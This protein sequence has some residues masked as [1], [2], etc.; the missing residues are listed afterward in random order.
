M[1]NLSI[2][3]ES[4]Q[5]K[6][7]QEVSPSDVEMCIDACKE[8]FNQILSGILEGENQE[9]HK[10][11]KSLFKE[12]M[13]LGLLLLNL[14]FANHN[15]G[16]YGEILKTSKGIARRGR[17]SEKSYFSVFGK[18]KVNRYLYNIGDESFAPLDTALNLPKRL[19]C[20][21]YFGHKKDNSYEQTCLTLSIKPLAFKLS[22]GQIT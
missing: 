14:F 1:S 4:T 8:Q 6:L 22:R 19:Y 18:L 15:Q 16:D 2:V 17:M 7:T 20:A 3:S 21:H 10:V 13:K 5:G 12:L 11:E 9:A